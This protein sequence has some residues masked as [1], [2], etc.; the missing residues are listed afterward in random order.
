MRYATQPWPRAGLAIGLA[1]CG[2]LAA[3]SSA[4]PPPAGHHSPA[5]RPP[6]TSP[7][8]QPSAGPAAVAAVRTLWLT[9]FNGAV[10]I[11]RRLTLLQGGQQFASFVHSQAR[12][13]LGALVFEAGAQ[14]SSVRLEPPAQAGVTYTI[15]LAGQPL[16]KDLAGTAV[17]SGGRWLVATAT[18]CGLVH[19]AYGTKPSLIPAACRG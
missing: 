18:F 14:V 6:A 10:P 12:T 9:F 17:Y 4:S 5:T 7:A 2:V 19:R 11:S 16:A 13:S 3:C 8:A 15:L 1:A